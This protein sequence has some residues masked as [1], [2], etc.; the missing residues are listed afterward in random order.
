MLL[1][2]GGLWL[3]HQKRL[4]TNVLADQPLTLTFTLMGDLCN[5]SAVIKFT[6]YLFCFIELRQLLNLVLGFPQHSQVTQYICVQNKPIHLNIKDSVPL[7]RCCLCCINSFS[8]QLLYMYYLI[9]PI[10]AHLHAFKWKWNIFHQYKWILIQLQDPCLKG[11]FI[12]QWQVQ[13]KHANRLTD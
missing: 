2:G 7:Q 3:C 1:L 10:I 12:H 8:R 4:K 13:V 5:L 9:E 11:K 6:W